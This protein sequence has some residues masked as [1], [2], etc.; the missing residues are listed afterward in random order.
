M[1]GGLT[2]SDVDR[3][4]EPAPGEPRAQAATLAPDRRPGVVGGVALADLDPAP[5]GRRR[6]AR[7]GR[8]PVVAGLAG[9]GVA[10][11]AGAAAGW[12]SGLLDGST[13]PT[14][15]A[16]S[17]RNADTAAD[18]GGFANRDESY[19]NSAGGRISA[20]VEP[21]PTLVFPTA[22]EAAAGTTVTVPTILDTSNPVLHLLRRTTFGLTPEL[23][24]D[25]HA[26][27]MDAW[28]AAQLDPTS[29]P[30]PEGDAAWAVWPLASADPATV[31]ASV[32][33]G[34]W[35][36]G[37]EFSTATMARQMWSSRQLFEVVVDF[38]SN[39]LN[40][41]TP[42]P[43][44]WDVGGSY[45]RDVIRAHAFGTFA[46]M[47]V[48]AGRHPAVLRYLT[49]DK[50]KK[51]SVN[52]NYGRELLELHTVGVASGYTEDDVRNS[53]YI[54]T[55]RTVTGEQDMSGEGAFRYDPAMHWV[56]PVT[57]LD[58]AHPNP[59]P[60][61]G[62]DVGDAYLRHLAGHPATART[63]A[64]KLAVRFVSDTPPATLVDRLATAYLDGGTAITPVLDLLFRSAE[65]WAAVGQKTRRPA[66]NIAASVRILGTVPEGDA[67][68]GV[69]ALASAVSRAGHK[70]IAW[71]APNGYP[72]VHAAWRSASSIVTAW[73]V[74]RMLIGDWEDGLT[75]PDPVAMAGGA[76]TV[77]AFVDNLCSRICFQGFQ[78]VHRDALVGFL[79]G[80]PAA[81]VRNDLAAPALALV[82]D[83]PYFALR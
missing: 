59:T 67:A 46:D 44:S 58:F 56:G 70:P 51:D 28:L 34:S 74:H 17:R 36:A 16:A 47:L 10:A 7:W 40:V 8:R 25:V 22:G 61:D 48:A 38:W 81:P 26:A 41:P 57:V 6:L 76:T 32:R 33:R 73:N 49:A 3:G 69:S 29:L 54:L 30:D 31:R 5:A 13:P 12:R 50:S 35:D 15:P 18:S 55:G 60:E 2:V 82:L 62:L 42:G 71:S 75:R 9:L 21:G 77:G 20:E 4:D 43:G 63:I 78:P 65:F 1:T 80:D 68:H 66:E 19:A 83:S 45:H 72:D 23:V 27:G 14:Q 11:A 39:H 24:A 37:H 64:A 79:G 52:E 53:A